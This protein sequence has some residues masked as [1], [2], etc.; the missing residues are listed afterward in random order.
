MVFEDV[1]K[2]ALKEIMEQ[3]NA[4]IKQE[5]A[6]TPELKLSRK[7]RRDVNAFFREDLGI[8][9]AHHPEVDNA[10]ERFRTHMYLKHTQYPWISRLN[11]SRKRRAKYTTM[12]S[13]NE[14]Q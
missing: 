14:T 6:E 5:I 4:K 1:L 12:A 7:S 8:D 10:W 9:H 11:K 2:L 3:E 13:D